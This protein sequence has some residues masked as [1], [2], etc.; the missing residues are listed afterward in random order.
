MV[1]VVRGNAGPGA[2]ELAA[3]ANA[4]AIPAICAACPGGAPGVT[5]RRRRR[6]AFAHAGAGAPSREDAVLTG[7]RLGPAVAT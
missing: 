5:R 4:I 1:H 7:A 2:D 6:F 3:R